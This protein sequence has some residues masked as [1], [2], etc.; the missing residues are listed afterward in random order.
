VRDA[1]LATAGRRA[2]PGEHGF[3]FFPGSHH[4]VPDS[5]RRIPL[6][7]NPN[8]VWRRPNAVDRP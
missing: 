1:T 6:P 8:G 2:L 4:H 7:R 5:M 3:R